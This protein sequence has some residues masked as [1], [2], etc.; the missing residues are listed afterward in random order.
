[1]SSGNVLVIPC[2]ALT[3]QKG[4]HVNVVVLRGKRERI[5][6]WVASIF[7]F[8]GT[9]FWPARLAGLLIIDLCWC[10]LFPGFSSAEIQK[11]RA[12]HPLLML[13]LR[14]EKPPA[15]SLDVL[16]ILNLLLSV[17]ATCPESWSAPLLLN[18]SPRRPA[19]HCIQAVTCSWMISWLSSNHKG[20]Y[21]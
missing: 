10:R 4:L 16:F 3:V 7:I 14:Q 15:A 1:M 8:H 5:S 21:V 20:L 19:I 13:S 2:F 6:H 12:G 11:N 17:W 18:Y 9:P